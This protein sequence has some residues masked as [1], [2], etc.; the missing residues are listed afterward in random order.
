MSV[1]NFPLL[2]A[3]IL[4]LQVVEAQTQRGLVF[5]EHVVCAMNFAR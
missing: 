2:F 4:D 1:P 5:V 3:Q